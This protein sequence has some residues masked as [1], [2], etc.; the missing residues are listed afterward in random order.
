MDF[1]VKTGCKIKDEMIE[2]LWMHVLAE[3]HHEEPVSKPELGHDQ[4]D[5]FPPTGLRSATEHQEARITGDN[6]DNPEAKEDA[7][8]TDEKDVPEPEKDVDFLVDDVQ[9]KYTETINVYDATRGTILVERTFW[10]FWEN[11]GH[12]VRTLLW[13]SVGYG[14]NF[15]AIGG[16]ISVEED[17]HEIHLSDDIDKV[18]ELAED[19]LVNIDIVGF[20]IPQDVTDN[21][22]SSFLSRFFTR[23]QSLCVEIL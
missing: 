2:Y 7:S 1:G 17:V 21:D 3:L 16:E 14:Q 23:I 19:E 9:R 8:P 15:W 13:R 4:G 5:V 22:A 11:F 18:E 20:E 10:H 12:G 6:G